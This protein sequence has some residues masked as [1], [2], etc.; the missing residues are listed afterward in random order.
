MRRATGHPTRKRS[1]FPISAVVGRRAGAEHGPLDTHNCQ[2]F[3]PL[4]DTE[5]MKPLAA[6]N[7]DV[8]ALAFGHFLFLFRTDGALKPHF[9][10]SNVSTS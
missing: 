6:T 4:F 1:Q 2:V 5:R 8:F 7:R 10:W 9:E 3:T